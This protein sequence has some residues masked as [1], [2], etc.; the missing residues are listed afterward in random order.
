VLQLETYSVR[1]LFDLGHPAH[2]H[3]F[4]NA[5]VELRAGGHD[6]VIFAREKDCLPELLEK[7]GWHYHMPCRKRGGQL[8]LGLEAVGIFARAVAMGLAR[9][10]DL[11]IGTSFVIGPASRITG[12]TSL[13]FSENDAAHVPLFV[14]L[15]YTSGHYVVTP[16]CLQSDLNRAKHLTYRGYQELAY[17]HPNRFRPDPGIRAELGLGED[18]KYFLIRKAAYT[19]F[20]D[21]GH[22]G[23]AGK[24]LQML[25]DRL[26]RH[27][28]VFL[29]IEA[30]LPGELQSCRLPTPADRMLDVLAFADMVVADSATVTI[31]AGVL[32][33]PAA[34]CSTFVGDLAI[35]KELEHKYG[36][37]AGYR[38]EDFDG[39]VARIDEW[40]MTPNLKDRWQQRRS[41]MLGEC[42]D[43]TAWIL[44]LLG[45]LSPRGEAAKGHK[46]LG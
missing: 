43:L 17:L 24:Q 42:V 25:I 20:H 37:I 19:A 11:M 18:E 46:R 23:L 15:A 5:I 21:V 32:G 12:A 2:F 41:R 44:D 1:L 6:V 36:L 31:E 34:W 9:P 28:R 45:R 4:K 22:T 29:S 10:F 26:A 30:D 13:V 38:P 16:R 14:K 27:G 3:L 33:T 35:L 39:L 40:L 8:R 7:T